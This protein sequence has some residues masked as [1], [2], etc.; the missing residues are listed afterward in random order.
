M[1]TTVTIDDDLYRELKERAART[2]RTVGAVLEDAVRDS[3]ARS[4]DDRKPFVVRPFKGKGGLRP[5]ID[6]SSNASVAEAMDEGVFLSADHGFKRFDG[7]RWQ[8]PL[9]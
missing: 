8:H 4:S 9:A 7:L 6:L 5:G 1:R 2:G 3:M